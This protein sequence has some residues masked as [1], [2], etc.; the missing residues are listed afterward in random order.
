MAQDSVGYSLRTRQGMYGMHFSI[1]RVSMVVMQIQGQWWV[2]A[3]GEAT[4]RLRVKPKVVFTPQRNRTH[5]S[6]Y[7][8]W[9]RCTNPTHPAWD[10]YGGRG[11][12]VC[13]RWVSFDNFLADMGLRPLGMSL[14]KI[15]NDRGYSPDNCRWATQ[16]EQNLNK[17]NGTRLTYNGETLSVTE[18][19][20]RLGVRRHVIFSRLKIGWSVERA[21][22]EPLQLKKS[23][24]KVMA[25]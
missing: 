18:W 5:R 21:L 7:A 6:W 2:G 25:Q 10:H 24:S 17:T 13:E 1:G 3:I 22:T 23:H 15:D 20:E 4:R 11:I 19:A 16:R 8:M 14:D 9:D 12:T